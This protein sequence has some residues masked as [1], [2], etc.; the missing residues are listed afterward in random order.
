ME[1]AGMCLVDCRQIII[2]NLD[3][4]FKMV[5]LYRKLFD[6]YFRWPFCFQAGKAYTNVMIRPL[7]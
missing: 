1:C 6:F 7:I 4:F 5:A 3:M 2:F